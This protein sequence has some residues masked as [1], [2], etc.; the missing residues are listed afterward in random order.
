M[1]SDNADG[2]EKAALSYRYWWSEKKDAPQAQPVKLDAESQKLVEHTAMERTASGLSSWNGAG[3]FEERD[4]S[5][6]GESRI[7]EMLVGLKAGAVSIEEVTAAKGDA[8]IVVSRGKKRAGF[9]Y[10]VSFKWNAG[11]VTG[12]ATVPSASLDDLDEIE[13]TNVKV[14]G[15][16]KGRE[17]EEAAGIAGAKALKA[18]IQEA[19]EAFA[20]ELKAR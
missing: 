7:K 10:E 19:F 14:N 5:G 6:W 12:T 18:P 4:F 9:D 8:S 2:D 1:A 11:D 3:T 15:K 20:E 13:V 16:K 17:T